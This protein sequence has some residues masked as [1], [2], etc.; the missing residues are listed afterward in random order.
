MQWNTVGVGYNCRGI[1]V[2]LSK[3]AVKLYKTEVKPRG[4]ICF[5]N[6]T[7]SPAHGYITTAILGSPEPVSPERAGMKKTFVSATD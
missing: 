6:L 5:K 4:E 7:P 2:K 1:E 3:N